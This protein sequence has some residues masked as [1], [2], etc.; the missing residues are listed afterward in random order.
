ML[1]VRKNALVGREAELSHLV[2][3]LESSAAGK[4]VVTLIS[5][6]AGV[7]K[8]RLVTELAARARE[9]GFTVMS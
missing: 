3:M 7:G 9:S 4:P 5:G 2:R 1:G 6:D 8:T